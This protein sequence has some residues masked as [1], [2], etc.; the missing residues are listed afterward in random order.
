MNLPVEIIKSAEKNTS[1]TSSAEVKKEA[2][3]IT[4]LE[5]IVSSYKKLDEKI[6]RCNDSIKE[7]RIKVTK[8]KEEKEKLQ[9]NI[10]ISSTSTS[11]E[12]VPSSDSD[13]MSREIK[14]NNTSAQEE[15]S[16]FAIKHIENIRSNISTNSE[17]AQESIEPLEASVELLK[18]Q[19]RYTQY[20]EKTLEL[21]SKK[22]KVKEKIKESNEII[23]MLAEQLASQD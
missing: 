21:F 3:S 5:N 16:S 22:K 1:N 9:L 20:L 6:H 4:L 13:L 23:S 7:M 15:T 12:N 14:N 17:K 8:L 2:S 10:S 18:I 11:F 19:V